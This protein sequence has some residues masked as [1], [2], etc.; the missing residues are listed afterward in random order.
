MKKK[1]RQS[2]LWELSIGDSKPKSYL[3]GTMHVKDYRAFI[4]QDIVTEYIDSCKIFATEFDLRERTQLNDPNIAKIPDGHTLRGILGEHKYKRTR[5]SI[6]RSF[7]IDLDQVLTTLPIFIINLLTEKVLVSSNSIPLDTFLWQYA[8][9]TH[10][11]LRGV[12]TYA[13]QLMTLDQIPLNYQVKSLIEIAAQPQKFRKQINKLIEMYVKNDVIGLYKKSKK[14]LGKQKKLLLYNRNK[15]MAERINMLIHEQS[16][17]VAVG[18]A[19]LSGK[20]GL[21]TLLK[22]SKIKSKPVFIDLY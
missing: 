8:E 22:K 20:H 16:S 13:E 11:D 10:R 12:E 1:K 9:N 6:K 17:F 7:N 15:V 14:S 4:F 5:K 2:L 18:A 21:I 3:F 19:H